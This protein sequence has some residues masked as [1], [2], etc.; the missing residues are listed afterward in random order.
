MEPQLS[1][2][3]EEPQERVFRAFRLPLALPLGLRIFSI[4][5]RLW[6]RPVRLQRKKLR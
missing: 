4:K 1:T 2:A 5:R 6:L 3:S